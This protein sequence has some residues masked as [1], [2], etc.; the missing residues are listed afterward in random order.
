MKHSIK[1][2]LA[3]DHSI[4]RVGLASLLSRE[5]DMTVVGEAENGE[6]AVAKA[7]ELKPDVVTTKRKKWRVVDEG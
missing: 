1:I 3:D 5:K 6:E 7:C 4:M 2:L